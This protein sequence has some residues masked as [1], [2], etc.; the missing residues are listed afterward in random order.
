LFNPFGPDTLTEVLRRLECGLRIWPRPVRIAYVNPTHDDV[1]A[2]S[3]WLA[4]YDKW[5]PW[6]LRWLVSF[7]KTG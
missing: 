4:R 1:L 7:R 5:K 2:E 6:E 3:G